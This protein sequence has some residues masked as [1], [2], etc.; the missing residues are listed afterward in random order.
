MNRQSKGSNSGPRPEARRRDRIHRGG[1]RVRL[2]APEWL[3]DRVLLS[4]QTYTVNQ[5]SD[6]GAGSGTSGDL[7]YCVTQADNNS[8][9]TIQF[10]VS[11]TIALTSDLP[12]LTA[13][14]T[15]EGPGAS[16]LTVQG[17]SYSRVFY[18]SGATVTI[19]GLTIAN[20]TVTGGGLGGGILNWN[21]TL[22]VTDCTFTGDSA[23][24]GGAIDNNGTMT[25][26]GSTFSSNNAAGGGAIFNTG[27]A[28]VTDSTFSNDQASYGGGAITNE[29]QLTVTGCTFNGNT[30]SSIARGG[31]VYNYFATATISN[32]TFV[33]NSAGLG[34]GLDDY[35]SSSAPGASHAFATLTDVTMTGSSGGGIDNEND[36]NGDLT[37]V[38]SLIAGN[39]G[40]DVIGLIN[41]YNSTYNL[42]GDGSQMYGISNGSNGNQVGTSSNPINAMLGTLAGN[43]GPTQT[44]ALLTG[45][46][47]LDAGSGAA[48]TDT[49]QRGVPRGT[50][51]DIGAYQAT[52][53]QLNVA[54]FPSPT[55]PGASHSFTVDA[56][57]PFGQPSLDF[58][59]SVTFSSSDPAANLPTG[60]ALVAGQGNFSA[61]LNTPGVQSITASA[62]GLQRLADGNRRQRRRHRDVPEAGR[63]D[64]GQL[65]RDL[66]P[67]RHGHPGLYRRHPLL[68]LRLLLQRLALH[69]V[70][71]HLRHPRRPEPRQ[72]I[73][74][75]RRRRL[76]QQ[77][78]HELL[79]RR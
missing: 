13:N 62:G 42:I 21:G 57:D 58:N 4:G 64:L 27:T 67:R 75:P 19:S 7:R 32:S 55:A 23:N 9:S 69:L 30:V 36:L 5:L 12:Q 29:I 28:T 18:D 47:A 17:T 59:S 46:P 53:S 77:E 8:G 72:P 79:H 35:Y 14:M 48:T 68:R 22:T 60:Q 65:G 2:W 38:N 33:N 15:I 74:L 76:V 50:V 10:S 70:E 43:G 41:P 34:G 56:V 11:G 6:T 24:T 25:V 52:A 66:R 49:D 71:Q 3:E 40:G 16:N 26:S 39:S 44:V 63:D 61:T 45:S 31:A 73:R 78:R 54:G 37:L 1:R 51:L 20:G